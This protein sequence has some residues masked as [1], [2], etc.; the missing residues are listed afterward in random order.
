MDDLNKSL[1]LRLFA[2]Q[3]VNTAL[4]VVL[5]NA[6]LKDYVQGI[7]SS[8]N[9]DDMNPA[10]YASVG[11]NIMTTMIISVFSPHFHAILKC[12]RFKRGQSYASSSKVA[13]QRDLNARFVGP[14]ADYTKRYAQIFSTLATCYTFSAGMPLMNFIFF[15]C[16]VVGYAFDKMFFIRLYRKPPAYSNGLSA[17][18]TSFLPVIVILHLALA[19]WNFGNGTQIFHDQVEN[20]LIVSKVMQALRSASAPS[21]LLEG[22]ERVTKTQVLPV[23]VLFCL[24]VVILVF[25]LLLDLLIVVIKRVFNI[26]TCGLACKKKAPIMTSA[27]DPLRAEI[28]NVFVPTYSQAVSS[29]FQGSVYAMQGITSFSML[30]NPF[31]SEAFALTADFTR[32]HRSLSAVALFKLALQRHTPAYGGGGGGGDGGD[33]GLSR[34]SSF[35]APVVSRSFAHRMGRNLAAGASNFHLDRNG[36]STSMAVGSDGGGADGGDEYAD[37]NDEN[38]NGEDVLNGSD[39][40][41][42]H[43]SGRR[44][45]AAGSG[46][47]ASARQ[48]AL[49]TIVEGP[50][51]AVSLAT[52]PGNPFGPAHAANGISGA[53]GHDTLNPLRSIAGGGPGAGSSSLAEGLSGSAASHAL[54]PRVPGNISGGTA[55]SA[56]ALAGRLGGA[57]AS[58]AGGGS[59]TSAATS[60]SS[61]MLALGLGDHGFA[62]ALGLDNQYYEDAMLDGRPDLEVESASSPAVGGAAASSIAAAN[63]GRSGTGAPSNTNTDDDD[64]CCSSEE[65]CDSDSEADDPTA[66]DGEDPSAMDPETSDAIARMLRGPALDVKDL[67]DKLGVDT[68]ALKALQSRANNFAAVAGSANASARAPG[69]GSAAHRRA[70]ALRALTDDTATTFGT[71]DGLDL[72]VVDVGDAEVDVDDVEEEGR[73]GQSDAAA[74]PPSSASTVNGLAGGSGQLKV[75]GGSGLQE[76]APVEE[77]QEQGQADDSCSLEGSQQEEEAKEQEAEE[78]EATVA[79]DMV[80]QQLE[81]HADDAGDMNVDADDDE[82]EDEEEDDG[83]HKH[84]H[85]AAHATSSSFVSSS[86]AEAPSQS[87]DDLTNNSSGCSP[88]APTMLMSNSTGEEILPPEQQQEQVPHHHTHHDHTHQTAE[89]QIVAN[90]A[91]VV[92]IGSNPVVESASASFPIAADVDDDDEA[93]AESASSSAAAGSAAGSGSGGK[94]R[95]KKSKRKGKK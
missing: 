26:L 81:N 95:S 33:D 5:I 91:V 27:E 49:S 72:T 44:L 11:A 92:T 63:R 4:L 24:L 6:P 61:R 45:H 14:A 7:V 59:A 8:E 56:A 12:I 19:C 79:L 1:S 40:R 46:V 82:E 16:M 86:T 87:D 78:M 53:G 48:V 18:M 67:S 75:S 38:G 64:D 88:A 93:E 25:K 76:D 73:V 51:S 3:F 15:A 71:E 28:S 47:G 36:S 50:E 74:A 31:V 20:N 54:Q 60:F 55:S 43:A 58:A 52:S 66:G 32:L 57:A 21:F 41:Q 89:M 84:Q 70:E 85:A 80:Q 30:E 17:R 35:L 77:E 22:A 2:A 29:E 9:Y 69:S 13:S 34:Q 37:D 42:T 65:D 62:R 68:D 83:D 90:D 94:R 23:F 39:H 10:W